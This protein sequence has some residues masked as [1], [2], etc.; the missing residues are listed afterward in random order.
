MYL[1]NLNHEKMVVQASVLRMW[2]SK[3]CIKAYFHGT[4][5]VYLL[6]HY[7]FD[8]KLNLPETEKNG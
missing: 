2:G 6:S 5:L 4:I 8:T 1:T 7:R 3:K